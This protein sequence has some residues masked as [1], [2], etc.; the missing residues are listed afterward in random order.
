MLEGK[1]VVLVDDSIV[2][3]TTSL[4]I[5]QMVREAGATRSAHAHR[6]PADHP[7]LLLRRRHAGAVASCSPRA[8]R[9]RRWREFIKVDSLAF[10]SIDGLYR[11]VGEARRDDAGARNSA[12]PASPATIPP[13][14]DRL[15]RRR[16]GPPAL[17]ARRG[18]IG[19]NCSVGSTTWRRDGRLRRRR[20][21]RKA[22]DSPCLFRLCRNRAGG[23]HR[24]RRL[25]QCTKRFA[26]FSNIGVTTGSPVPDGRQCRATSALQ[27][28][29]S[30]LD[31]KT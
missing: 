19:L 15:R 14:L 7:L 9:S 29:M 1:R 25:G 24:G 4:K 2:R 30:G 22:A 12:T 10:M 16:Q 17:A 23:G 27:S 26:R 31:G 6:Q 21:R 13:A 8:C 18:G 11:A 20:S 5:V 28:V 3:G